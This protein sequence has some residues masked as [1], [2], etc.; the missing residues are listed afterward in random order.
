MK[1]ARHLIS[2]CD[3]KDHKESRWTPKSLR[4]SVRVMGTELSR[5]SKECKQD[6]PAKEPAMKRENFV[7]LRSALKEAQ[8]ATRS[9]SAFSVADVRELSAKRK[10]L[11]RITSSAYIKSLEKRGIVD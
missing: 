10:D 5:M 9:R 6:K 8:V 1:A 7:G 2:T 11:S 4:K 3:L